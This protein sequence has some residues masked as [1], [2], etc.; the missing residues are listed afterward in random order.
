[1]SAFLVITKHQIPKYEIKLSN[2]CQLSANCHRYVI[3]ELSRKMSV[4]HN[5]GTEYG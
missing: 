3:F 4:A 5:Y 2:H 1:M